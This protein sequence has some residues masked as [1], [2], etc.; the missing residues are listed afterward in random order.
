MGVTLGYLLSAAGAAVEIFEASGVLGGLAGPLVLPDGVEVDRFYHAIL[1]TDDHLRT[2]CHEV[3]LDDRLR[4]AVAEFQ[5]GTF[6]A[7]FA[8]QA[9]ADLDVVTAITERNF[10]RAHSQSIKTRAIVSKV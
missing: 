10:Y 7:E 5:P 2:L 6:R 3:G 8:E 9:G 1:P 4:F